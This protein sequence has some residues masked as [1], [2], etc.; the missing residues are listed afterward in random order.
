MSAELA[1]AIRSARLV[2][3]VG[4]VTQ[5]FGL[6]VEANGPEVFLGERCRIEAGE[7]GG[8][9]DAEVVG[10]KAGKVLLMPFGELRG[11]R[12]GCEVVGTAEPVRVPEIGRA[13]V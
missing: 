12:Q 10:L 13:H 8:G 2:R 11:I 4:Q 6:L 7:T 1:R 9:C 3:N 5:F